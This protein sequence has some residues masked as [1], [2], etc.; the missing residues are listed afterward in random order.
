MRAN[1]LEL[2]SGAR[3]DCRRLAGRIRAFPQRPR[4]IESQVAEIVADVRARGDEAVM[5]LT[6]RFDGVQ[7]PDS[8][9]V[10][11]AALD[12]ALGALDPQLRD[13]LELA[14]ANVRAVAEADMRRE[15]QAVVTLAQGQTV[16]LRDLAA[17]RVGAYVPGGKA[18]Y[19]STVLMCCLPAQVAG[20]G[21]VAV[22]SPPDA[23]GTPNQLVL[24]ASALCG[25]NE[26]YG[27][28]GAQAIAALAIGT[29]QIPPVDVI[30][31]PGSA[32]VQEAKR[33]LYGSVGLD[34]IAGPSELVVIADGDAQA[35]AIALD[36]G[37][38]AEHGAGSV[39]V[40]A[41][42]DR[43]LLDEVERLA[44][45]LAAREADE[46]EVPLALVLTP[47]LP[48]AIV[49]SN[50]LAPEHVELHVA[51]PEAAAEHVTA[52]GC[53][54]LGAY[55]ATAF[56]DYAAGSNHVL[57]TGGAARFSGPL[58]VGTFRRR[59]AL[60]SLPAVAADALAPHV[61]SIARAEGFP[62]HAESA[63]ARVQR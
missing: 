22:V 37:A 32:Y 47:D 6:G 54:F 62:I 10:P 38:Q 45:A 28:G 42:P 15:Q 51:D 63:E 36:L 56:G 19:P 31:G 30:V 12:Q 13:S 5:E 7:A 20:V 49:L 11:E 21:A 46:S 48:A 34:G 8:L 44:V 50:E 26:V 23:T 9:R 59:Q 60:V 53:V 29:E 57:P 3:A 16:M 35:A 14:A 4:E 58:G 2:A 40:L 55:S 43:E 33:Q 17:E 41:S 52:A 61:A 27:V 25:L 39:V 1:R 24:A 18:A